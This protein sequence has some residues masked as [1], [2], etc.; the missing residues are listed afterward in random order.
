MDLLQLIN[1]RYDEIV[2]EVTQG[3]ARIPLKRYGEED[4]RVNVRR[5]K[6]IIELSILC[7]RT[8]DLMPMIEYARQ[9]ARDRYEHGYTLQEVQ[10]AFN[11]GEEVIWKYITQDIPPSGYP[12]A[13]GMASTILGAGKE[14]L[15]VEYVELASQSHMPSLDLSALF[16]G[17]E[18]E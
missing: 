13:F 16:K 12:T 8:E 2:A 9:L 18:G 11:V 15:A 7:I 6:R 14:A 10:A 3:L 17:T 1:K 5:V 4:G